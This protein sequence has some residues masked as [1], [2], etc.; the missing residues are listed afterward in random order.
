MDK[1]SKRISLFADNFK[2]VHPP[3]T[4]HHKRYSNSLLKLGTLASHKRIYLLLLPSGPGR[5]HRFLLRKT[6]LSTPLIK[7]RPHNVSL[8]E[9]IPPCY[10]GLQV[11]GTATSPSST[12]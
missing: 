2:A 10:S 9:G 11:Q 3:S 6:K 5:V 4:I 7:V 8:R 1:K 12:A